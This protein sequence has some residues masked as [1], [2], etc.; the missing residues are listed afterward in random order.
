MYLPSIILRD[1]SLV[2]R[3]DSLESILYGTIEKTFDQEMGHGADLRRETREIF[4]IRQ[5]VIIL[6]EHFIMRIKDQ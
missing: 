2:I 5:D 4:G 1:R 6:S 3:L